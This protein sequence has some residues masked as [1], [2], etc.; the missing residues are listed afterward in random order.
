MCSWYRWDNPTAHCCYKKQ[1]LSL[2]L[3]LRSHC[4]YRPAWTL[5]PSTNLT[6]LYRPAKKKTRAKRRTSLQVFHQFHELTQLTLCPHQCHTQNKERVL[7][8]WIEA[9]KDGGRKGQSETSPTEW[10]QAGRTIWSSPAATFQWPALPLIFRWQRT[11]IRSRVRTESQ[12]LGRYYCEASMR[13][14]RH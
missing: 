14:T 5:K 7:S 12:T 9:R 1:P 3:L 11:E 10:H 6:Q 13:K 4:F 2:L 8:A